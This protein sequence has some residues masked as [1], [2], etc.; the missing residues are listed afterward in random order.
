[1]EG[2]DELRQRPMWR[3]AT[4]R[5]IRR[6]T[7]IIPPFSV[8]GDCGLPPWAWMWSCDGGM[9]L[10]FRL[11]NHV[12]QVSPKG[13]QQEPG[14]TQKR[15]GPRRPRRPTRPRR[16]WPP[17]I[18]LDD[19][20]WIVVLGDHRPSPRQR[21]VMTNEPALSLG[22]NRWAVRTASRSHRGHRPWRSHVHTSPKQLL[23]QGDFCHV[24]VA[25]TTAVGRDATTA[26]L[27]RNSLAY[28][29][30]TKPFCVRQCP[31]CS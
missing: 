2:G 29:L 5:L 25:A 1:M 13:R 15:S 26:T 3:C 18:D 16:S 6:H 9:G 11:S 4:P 8:A 14:R 17:V 7:A 30:A 27:I 10:R 24:V 23:P 21:T 22:F 19:P 20:I 12:G 31:R 28:L